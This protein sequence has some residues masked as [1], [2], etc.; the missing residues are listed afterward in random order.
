MLSR[1][2]VVTVLSIALLGL[3]AHSTALA[4]SRV[5][6]KVVTYR[7]GKTTMKGYIAYD[8]GQRG[9]RPGVLVVHEWWGHNK[10]ARRR[11][12]MLAKL[13]YVALA[14]DMYGGGKSTTHPK[15][16]KKF[17]MT[18]IGNMAE[19]KRRF[20]AAL[21]LLKRHPAT[22]KRRIAA[23]G[24]CFG[25]AVVLHMA[26]FGVDLRGVV[27]F[28][29]NLGTKTPAKKGAVKAAVLVL[30]GAADPF[31]PNK[32]VAAFKAEMKAAGVKMK[33]VAYPGAKHA[34][35]NPAASKIGRANKLPL[36]YNAAADR[37]SWAEMKRFFRRVLR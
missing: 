22:S 26:R 37:G 35:T 33:F 3:A 5:V 7:S 27:S 12:R 14:L 21:A 9:K 16:A 18:V 24:Y 8:A 6:G 34:F 2:L 29:G 17:M 1:R 28:H 13:G 31:V 30:H 19:G 15:D 20:L 25:G 23:I 32:Q 10:Y 4:G 36:A 11:A